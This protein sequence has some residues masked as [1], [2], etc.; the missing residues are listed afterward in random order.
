M[1]CY[2]INFIFKNIS[3]IKII[4][5]NLCIIQLKYR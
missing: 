3:N 5:S 1:Q 2:L 4:R